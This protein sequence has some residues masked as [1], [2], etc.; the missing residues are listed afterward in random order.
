MKNE[1]PKSLGMWGIL[2]AVPTHRLRY[3]NAP[4]YVVPSPN[5]ATPAYMK[6]NEDWKFQL[7][8]E[9]IAFF[10]KFIDSDSYKSAADSICSIG[11]DNPRIIWDK[12]VYQFIRLQLVEARGYSHGYDMV[13][14]SDYSYLVN[15]GVARES[16]TSTLNIQQVRCGVSVEDV[17]IEELYFVLYRMAVAGDCFMKAIRLVSEFYVGVPHL[18]RVVREAGACQLLGTGNSAVRIYALRN[19]FIWDDNQA[20]LIVRYIE[21]ASDNA[22]DREME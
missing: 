14:F 16:I 8:P 11:P 3:S 9:T 19:R 4:V 12:K 7:E 2:D 5:K 10:E 22:K 15:V 1:P 18:E 21:L 20:A 17:T 13:T 6:L